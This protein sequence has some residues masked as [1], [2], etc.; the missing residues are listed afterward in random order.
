MSI[1]FR[2]STPQVEGLLQV[3]KWLKTQVLLDSKEMGSLIEALF[4][5][6]IVSVSG[7]VSS[8]ESVVSAASFL[9]AY[10]EYVELL[11]KGLVPPVERFRRLFSCAL[12]RTLD[13]FY[14]MALGADRYLIKPVMPVIQLQAHHLF[15]STLDQKFHPM[16]FSAESTSW[17][18]QFSYPQLF[19]DPKTRGVV[20]V[21]DTERFVNSALFSTFLRWIRSHTVPTPFMVGGVRTN[22]PMRVGKLALS[23][24]ASHP[25]LKA[26]GI[27][28]CG[29]KK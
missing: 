14:A 1:I 7:P 15:Y 2:Q 13:S 4:P 28:L 3:S 26:Q 17:G 12:S 8:E 29:G 23:W 19:Q 16:V 22:V 18:L 9:E 20:K 10:T 5:F 11:K 6:Y 27:S 21:S 24:V 25:Q